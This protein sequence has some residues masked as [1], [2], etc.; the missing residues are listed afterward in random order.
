MHFQ[1]F[2]NAI[3]SDRE[4]MDYNKDEAARSRE[5]AE[6]KFLQHDLI[7]ARTFALKAQHLFPDLEG[8][9]HLMAVLDVYIV[10]QD[11]VNGVEDN[12][13]GILQADPAA[14][15]A[16]IKRQYRK[17][18]LI[19]HPDKNRA[20]GAE[21]A[22]KL[23]SKAWEVLSDKIKRAAH[24]A[25][26]RANIYHSGLMST[27]GKGASESSRGFYNIPRYHTGNRSQANPARKSDAFWTAC[28]FC[29][30]QFEYLRVYENQELACPTCSEPFL[31]TEI[32]IVS[33][34]ASWHPREQH[35]SNMKGGFS[36][37]QSKTFSNWG[38]ANSFPNFNF[39]WGSYRNSA[40]NRAAATAEMVH[41]TY[42]TVRRERVRSQ[43]EAREKMK[44]ER[45][46]AHKQARRR[47]HRVEKQRRR[48][49]ELEKKAKAAAQA[50]D[51]FDR[52]FA[53]SSMKSEHNTSPECSGAQLNVDSTNNSQPNRRR[54]DYIPEEEV[55]EN[56]VKDREDQTQENHSRKDEHVK[57]M[58]VLA[59]D[60]A[61]SQVPSTSGSC[62]HVSRCKRNAS[63]EFAS[64]SDN[65]N[66]S[67]FS[68]RS[69]VEGQGS[70]FW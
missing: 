68:K 13:Y 29:K 70:S 63:S 6:Q 11:K 53:R 25:R 39:F 28:P 51:A 41:Q 40:A 42:E 5:I 37:H 30:I 20:V 19:L 52:L 15:D 2:T 31:A 16:T 65:Q 62:S 67:C 9:T 44:K 49:K 3:V 57:E 23:L 32:P 36:H 50:K 33:E 45:A 46:E 54:S 22:F 61:S 64:G 12:W 34:N 35:S 56:L 43:E 24:D 58:D 8:L 48:E 38:R 4:N 14:D 69:R 60:K 17:L 10:A 7:G 26:R 21:G 18:A 1:F 59:S 66:E 55:L 47:E 27:K